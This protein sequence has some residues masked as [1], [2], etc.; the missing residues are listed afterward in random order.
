MSRCNFASCTRHRLQLKKHSKFRVWDHDALMTGNVTWL[1]P[2]AISFHEIRIVLLSR[3]ITSRL[4]Q[5]CSNSNFVDQHDPSPCRLIAWSSWSK[6]ARVASKLKSS[7][8]PESGTVDEP[9]LN[10][11]WNR[12]N[13]GIRA[14]VQRGIVSRKKCWENE[15]AVD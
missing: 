3:K 15:V 6:I 10:I 13:P 7:M 9:S 12:C 4:P 2:Y 5:K 1:L 11:F 8:L 14:L